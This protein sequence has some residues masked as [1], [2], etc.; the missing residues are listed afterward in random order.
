MVKY[1]ICSIIFL[2]LVLFLYIGSKGRIE[3]KNQ[4]TGKLEDLGPVSDVEKDALFKGKHKSL[5]F[6]QGFFH[7]FLITLIVFLIWSL[8][9]WLVS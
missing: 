3:G 8:I 2:F 4:Y 1:I 5:A 7:S 6:F 9:E